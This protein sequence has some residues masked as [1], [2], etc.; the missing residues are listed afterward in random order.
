MQKLNGTV[1]GICVFESRLVAPPLAG[2]RPSRGEGEVECRLWVNHVFTLPPGGS[3]A[4]AAGEGGGSFGGAFLLPR[5]F[6]CQTQSATA[7]PLP[8]LGLDP[9]GGG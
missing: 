2:A 4:V 1:H 9:P 8:S 5:H 3:D 6:T 7:R